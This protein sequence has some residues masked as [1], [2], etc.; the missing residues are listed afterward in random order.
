MK[1]KTRKPTT[2]LEPDCQVTDD[3]PDVKFMNEVCA[4]IRERVKDID[5]RIEA[6]RNI[7]TGLEEALNIVEGATPRVE[8]N[9]SV[10]IV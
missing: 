5:R 8:D 6:L 3:S 1:R 10:K 4:T 9:Y 2:F 7:Q